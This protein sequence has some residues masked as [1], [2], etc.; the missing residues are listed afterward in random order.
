METIV[1]HGEAP[2]VCVPPL[3]T[4]YPRRAVPTNPTNSRPNHEARLSCGLVAACDGAPLGLAFAQYLR[5]E[6]EALTRPFRRGD[7]ARNHRDRIDEQIVREPHRLA[8][9]AGGEGCEEVHVQL[10]GHVG[11][12]RYAEL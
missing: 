4:P 12:D 11:R 7:H 9:E 10:R 8:P 3:P 1:T 6:G 5:P 2:I